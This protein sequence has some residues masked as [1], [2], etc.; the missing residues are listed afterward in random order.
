MGLHPPPIPSQAYTANELSAIE[1]RPATVPIVAAFLFAAAAIAA[2]VAASLLFPGTLLDRL[3]DI[4]KPG[5]AAVRALGRIA[6]ILLLLLG[7]A[8]F[9]AALALLQRRNWAWW[10][11]VVW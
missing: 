11:A 4:D 10:F 5:A 9:A 8:T 1:Q 2:V 7:A 6:A 3:W